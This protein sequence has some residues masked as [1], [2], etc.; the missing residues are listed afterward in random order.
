MSRDAATPVSDLM[1]LSIHPRHVASILAGEKTVEL[2]R[3]RPNV[4]PGQPIAIYST[5]PESALVATGRVAHVEVSG[6]ASLRSSTLLDAA[7]VS[8]E[9]Y[10]A[11][12]A[13]A[14]RAVAL[15]LTDITQLRHRV[16]LSQLRERVRYSP[17]QTWHFFDAAG[18]GSLG[19][20]QGT[21]R[22]SGNDLIGRH[23]RA[24]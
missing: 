22:N 9:E 6:P 8:R 2:R 7:R 12:F 5:S 15:H 13:G 24:S 19:G 10:D 1:V 18:R 17:P 4:A 20:S 16:A 14:E 21:P 11:Y 23:R 3:T